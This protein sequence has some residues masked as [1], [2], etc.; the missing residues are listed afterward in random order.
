MKHYSNFNGSIFLSGNILWSEIGSRIFTLF[1]KYI[2]RQFFEEL[3]YYMFQFKHKKNITIKELLR[4]GFVKIENYLGIDEV[5]SLKA[6]I[7]DNY[8]SE[9][10]NR[11]FFNK[12]R[13]I[14]CSVISRLK[15]DPFLHECNKAVTNSEVKPS[16]LYT[17]TIKSDDDVNIP[18]SHVHFDS[19]KHELKVLIPLTN[20][21]KMN[22]PTEFLKGSQHYRFRYTKQYF[23]SW[24]KTRGYITENKMNDISPSELKE[25]I[26]F[27]CNI[28][29][30][31]IFDS[32][33][34]H[35]ATNIYLGERSIIWLYY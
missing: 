17:R 34:L 10:S 4:D 22:G 8:K 27:T 30:I 35:R 24:L 1:P 11:R 3:R 16:A 12:I 23:V 14:N 33:A 2:I 32:R 21:S 5:N 25:S 15:L 19:F 9:L 29:D 28:G 20:I 7:E 13:D 18:A 26:F 6:Y 31:I